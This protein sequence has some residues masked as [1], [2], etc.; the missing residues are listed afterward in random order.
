MNE[1]AYWIK[2]EDEKELQT[3]NYWNDSEVEKSKAWFVKDKENSLKF[4]SFLKEKKLLDEYKNIEPFI[5]KQGNN[6]EVADL[7]CGTGWASSLISK[8]SEVKKIY[9]VEFSKHRLIDLLP[10]TVEIL[11]GLSNKIFPCYGSFYDCKITSNSIDIVFLSQAFHHADTPILLAAETKRILKKG[12]KVIMIG[13]KTITN[14]FIIKRYLKHLF[15]T[16]KIIPS[17][18]D[19]LPK[20]ELKGD[21]H[22]PNQT[23]DFIW[24]GLGLEK[25][26]SKNFSHGISA[27]VFEK[28]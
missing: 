12:G 28:T 6:L 26:Y 5:K 22:F 4:Y 11:G 23:Y 27:Y 15:K 3:F 7:A 13:E 8:L 1:V 9:C 10:K 24:G 21:N 19:L 17:L 16:G 14:L 2:E 25:I 20:D 18:R